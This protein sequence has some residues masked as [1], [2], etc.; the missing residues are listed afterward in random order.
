MMMMMMMMMMITI[1][2]MK[3]RKMNNVSMIDL[4]E[5]VIIDSYKCNFAKIIEVRL[6]SL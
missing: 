1:I 5:V 6:A 2:I 4:I 3:N